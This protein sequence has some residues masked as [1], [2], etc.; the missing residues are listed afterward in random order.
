MQRI[1]AVKFEMWNEFAAE[2]RPLLD[3]IQQRYELNMSR[4]HSRQVLFIRLILL[5][6]LSLLERIN[7][8]I[9]TKHKNIRLDNAETIIN[10]IVKILE[11]NKR[12]ELEY[13]LVIPALEFAVEGLKALV[14][15]RDTNP[16]T[17][18]PRARRK[19]TAIAKCQN[20]PKNLMR[21]RG[22]YVLNP[23]N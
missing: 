21:K 17:L 22:I 1:Q 14:H 9:S 8:H 7:I 18:T 12:N 20:R 11:F 2:L 19:I 15:L 10:N 5:Y 23:I 6:F 16:S 13:R 4:L 3:E